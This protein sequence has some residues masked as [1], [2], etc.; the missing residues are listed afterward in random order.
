MAFPSPIVLKDA[1]N[2][3]ENFVRLN[4]DSQKVNYL[5]EGS[6]LSEPVALQIGHQMTTSPQGND[7]HLVKVSRTVVDSEGAP[8]TCV[9]N[10]TLSVPRV[11]ITSADVKDSVAEVVSFLTT[12]NVDAIL[13]GEL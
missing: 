9:L 8:R 2:A 4:G 13:R 12:A 11:G 6:T 7:R 5:F 3:N 1:A 10:F